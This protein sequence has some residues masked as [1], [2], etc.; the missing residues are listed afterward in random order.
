MSENIIKNQGKTWNRFCLNHKIVLYQ[1]ISISVEKCMFFLL[2]NF[3]KMTGQVSTE[4]YII[5]FVTK[6]VSCRVIGLK[7][8]ATLQFFTTMSG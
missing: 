2:R 1:F 6:N 4:K 5:V 7:I 8:S 3:A